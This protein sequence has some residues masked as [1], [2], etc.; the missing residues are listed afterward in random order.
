MIAVFFKKVFNQDKDYEHIVTY[1]IDF[2]LV[3]I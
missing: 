1:I 2:T 3:D